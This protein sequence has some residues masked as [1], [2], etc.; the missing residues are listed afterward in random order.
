LKKGVKV[1]GHILIRISLV[2]G[3]KLVSLRASTTKV[4]RLCKPTST[5]KGLWLIA[6]VSRKIELGP[7]GYIQ[8]DGEGKADSQSAPSM[9][10]Y[11][12]CMRNR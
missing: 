6:V 10:I 9:R 11:P 2:I 8:A 3:P 12:L 5:R 7:K 1:W 4:A